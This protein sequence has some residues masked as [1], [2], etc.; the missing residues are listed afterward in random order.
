MAAGL[1]AD[2]DPS[3]SGPAPIQPEFFEGNFMKR[4]EPR[5]PHGTGIEEQTAR[6]LAEAVIRD[7]RDYAIFLLD[8]E[9]R[10]ASWNVGAE[11][12]KGYTADEIIGS[13]FSRFYPPEAIA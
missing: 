1:A 12:I 4:F 9:G 8:P 7:V 3:R 13:H 10:V 11:R 2:P 6:W 5:P